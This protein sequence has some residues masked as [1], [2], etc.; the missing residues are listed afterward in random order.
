MFPFKLVVSTYLNMEW[1]QSKFQVKL[2]LFDCTVLSIYICITLNSSDTSDTF[3]FFSVLK[4]M[5]WPLCWQTIN[6]SKCLSAKFK[7]HNSEKDEHGNFLGNTWQALKTYIPTIVAVTVQLS[8]WRFGRVHQ[9]CWKK[10]TQSLHQN[11]M[12]L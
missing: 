6:Y 3:F 7:E 8:K 11:K 5:E 10:L 12:W 2:R 9:G 1:W 4:I